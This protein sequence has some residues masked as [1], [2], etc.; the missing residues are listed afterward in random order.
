MP[1]ENLKEKNLKKIVSELRFDIVSED[2]VVIATGRAKRPEDFQRERRQPIKEK[3]DCPFCTL[4]GQFPPVYQ[5]K[6]IIVIP[7]LYPAFSNPAPSLKKEKNQE[8][9]EEQDYGGPYKKMEG[10]GF[11]E[12]IITKDHYRQIAQFSVEEIKEVIDC[13]LARYEELMKIKFVNYISIFHNHGKEAG[14]SMSHPHSQL[15]AIPIIDPDIKRSLN[16]SK[17]YWKKYGKCPHC[18]M[19]RWDI[20][21]GKRVVFENKDFVVVC[22]FAS[23]VAFEIRIYPK[24]HEAYFE[25][26]SEKEKDS[27]AEAFQIAISSLYKGLDDPPYNFF[28]HTAPCD[29]EDHSHYH[30]HFEII[31]KTDMPAGFELGTG[32]EIATIEPEKAAEHLKKFKRSF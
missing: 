20:E 6:N 10:I 11:H 8:R 21:E 30:W 24:R 7:N 13:Y 17:R 16:G 28:L 32:I 27:L 14:A 4:K 2:W 31:P 15:I 9:I 19:I 29:E 22:P 1:K 18:T 5:S 26:I 12:V 3:K 25:K 23:K